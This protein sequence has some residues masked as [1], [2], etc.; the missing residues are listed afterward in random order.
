[1]NEPKTPLASTLGTIRS[2]LRWARRRLYYQ[3]CR[4]FGHDYWI[5]LEAPVSGPLLYTCQ[6]CDKVLIQYRDEGD[7]TVRYEDH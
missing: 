1:M 6:R 4:L 2:R 5:T 3:F 7:L